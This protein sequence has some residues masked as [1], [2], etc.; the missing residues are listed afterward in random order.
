[1]S[2]VE[3]VAVRREP[4]L[5]STEVVLPQVVLMPICVGMT[6]TWTVPECVLPLEASLPVPEVLDG[7]SVIVNSKVRTE[8]IEE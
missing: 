5:L 8:W 3:P 1:M 2:W 4:G 6:W 7:M